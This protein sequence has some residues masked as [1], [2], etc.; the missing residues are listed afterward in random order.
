MVRIFFDKVGEVCGW[1]YYQLVDVFCVD[2][3]FEDVSLDD[4]DV[5]LLFGG[6]VNFDQ[7]CSL[8][9]VQE[10]VICV[11]QV[12][13]LVVVI[14]YGVWLLIF[15]GLVQGCILISWLLFKDDIN[16][17]GG[18]WVDQEVVVDG[19]L[20]SSCKFEDILVFNC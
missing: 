6:V 11:E 15:V 12:S 16:N 13:K 7:I 17:V 5:L 20:V 1:N 9:K 19:K 4:Y 18:Y 8:V 2:G 10:L 3:I 14:C